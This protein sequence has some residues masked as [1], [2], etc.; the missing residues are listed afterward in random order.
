MIVRFQLLFAGSPTL[1]PLAS[2]LCPEGRGGRSQ[3]GCA[4]AGGGHG[5]H[6][7]LAKGPAPPLA[8]GLRLVLEQVYPC[9][10]VTKSVSGSRGLDQDSNGRKEDI[11]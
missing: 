9:S 8:P 6:G 3:G 5:V 2:A 1:S 4:A 11:R 10:V 7:C